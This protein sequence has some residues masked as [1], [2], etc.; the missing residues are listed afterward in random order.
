MFI[1]WY[2]LRCLYLRVDVQWKQEE[3]S[4]HALQGKLVEGEYPHQSMPACLAAAS[5]GAIGHAT[6]FLFFLSPG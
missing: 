5:V 3:E 1:I 4:M 6:R 2:V